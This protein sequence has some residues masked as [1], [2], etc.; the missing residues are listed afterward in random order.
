MEPQTPVIQT[1][2]VGMKLSGFKE[3]LTKRSFADAFDDDDDTIDTPTRHTK[4]TQLEAPYKS[5]D[6]TLTR[7]YIRLA[8]HCERTGH[9]TRPQLGFTVRCITDTE[10]QY[11]KAVMDVLAVY[12]ETRMGCTFGSFLEEIYPNNTTKMK[13]LV[14]ESLMKQASSQAMSAA[15]TMLSNGVAAFGAILLARAF[16]W[17]VKGDARLMPRNVALTGSITE[18]HSALLVRTREHRNE[19]GLLYIVL[20]SPC[21]LNSRYMTHERFIEE[22]WWGCKG[23]W[24]S[25]M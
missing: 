25:R 17:N 18:D 24:E 3:R 16:G 15:C 20:P 14:K 1:P 4:T 12:D 13:S 8:Q 23:D 19:N 21:V 9:I 11:H 10:H 6:E 2:N 22:V 5:K 7:Y